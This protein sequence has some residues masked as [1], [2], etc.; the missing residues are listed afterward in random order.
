M[1]EK[2]TKQRQLLNSKLGLDVACK[3]GMDFGE[4]YTN[5]DLYISRTSANQECNRVS[6]IVIVIDV[7]SYVVGFVTSIAGPSSLFFSSFGKKNLSKNSDLLYRYIFL[8]VLS[9]P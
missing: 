5:D 4:M 3:L 6:P 2:L 7:Q 1:K 8:V 9:R